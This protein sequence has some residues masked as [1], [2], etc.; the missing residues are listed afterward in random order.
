MM[1]LNQEEKKE[2]VMSKRSN[3]LIFNPDPSSEADDA[4][5]P[6][7]ASARWNLEYAVELAS[8]ERFAEVVARIGVTDDE[9]EV[10][11]R[12]AATLF[13]PSPN[14]AGVVEEFDGYFGLDSDLEGIT[15]SY[16]R[17]SQAVKQPVSCWP[18][19]ALKTFILWRCARPTGATT[20]VGRCTDLR[21]RSRGWLMPPP[22][23][24]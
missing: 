11:R 2:N 13:I 12:K 14:E 23:A 1:T 22:V 6:R 20:T 7:K 21:S 24:A 4:R 9:V 10:W 8:D 17:H 5:C 19:C 18:P 16:C 15:E 3:V